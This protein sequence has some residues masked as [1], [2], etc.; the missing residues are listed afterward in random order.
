MEAAAPLSIQSA[1]YSNI[2]SR[3][4]IH[5]MKA[6]LNRGNAGYFHVLN[7]SVTMR[8]LLALCMQNMKGAKRIIREW[9]F[10]TLCT[11][12]APLYS[13]MSVILLNSIDI[14]ESSVDALPLPY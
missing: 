9:G 8:M 13:C 4:W 2:G 5:K 12:I 7:Y 6:C 1:G 11:V 14:T 3:L 10:P